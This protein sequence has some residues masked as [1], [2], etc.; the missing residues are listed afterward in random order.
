M[1]KTGFEFITLRQEF[2]SPPDYH[3]RFSGG[4]FL[5]YFW[6]FIWFYFFPISTIRGYFLLRL[7]FIVSFLF[8][9]CY[10]QA[11][12]DQGDDSCRSG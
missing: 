5:G 11:W 1:D 7:K 6:G 2:E 4:G 12:E 8:Y 10:E 9:E 3:L